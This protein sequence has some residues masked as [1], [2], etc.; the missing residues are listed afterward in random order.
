MHAPAK[1]GEWTDGWRIVAAAAL[2]NATGISLL[3][4]TF[5]LFVLPMAA[6]LHLTRGQGGIIQ[7]M[8]ITAALGAPLIGRLADRLGFHRLFLACTLAMVAT[9]IALWRWADSFTALALG[10]ALIGFIGGGSASVLLTRPVNAH[11]TRNRGLALGLVGTGIS[12]TTVFVPPWL[13][14]VIAAQGWRSGFLVLAGFALV[15]GLP[16]V[17]A[18]MPRNASTRGL[19]AAGPSNRDYLHNRDFW[20]LVAANVCASIATAAA[21]SQLSP[22]LQERGLSPASAALGIS[23]FAAGQFIGKLG[24][25]WLLDRFE[26]RLVAALLNALPTLGFVL[27]LTQHGSFLPLML[28]VGLIGVLQGADIGIFAYFVAHRFD[29]ARYGAIFGSLHGIGWIGTAAGVVG[30]GLSYDRYGGYWAA[31]I[32]AIGLL[33]LAAL[34]IPLIR[35]KPVPSGSAGKA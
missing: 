19:A 2:A 26:P 8:I 15:L 25:G 18:L 13:Q 6:D 10:T 22:M 27:L 34:L 31:Q 5:N 20:V 21:I 4:Y 30:A 12:L 7:S 1:S 11:F 35:L 29:V 33:L 16:A 14:T 3:F 28:A 9:E 24:G 23:S 17:L 32:A